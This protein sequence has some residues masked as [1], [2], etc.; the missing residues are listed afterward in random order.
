MRAITT[1]GV[2]LV[3]AISF[4]IVWTSITLEPIDIF[5]LRTE[6]AMVQAQAAVLQAMG[7]FLGIVAMVLIAAYSEISRKT[8]REREAGERE[9]VRRTEAERLEKENRRKLR[10][11]QRH[12][13]S[14]A[15]NLMTTA[16]GLGA[17]Y[18]RLD[19][20]SMTPDQANAFYYE[21]IIWTNGPIENTS[22]F[23]RLDD[24][25]MELFVDLVSQIDDYRTMHARLHGSGSE[26]SKTELV[27][28]HRS[29]HS[30]LQSIEGK[31]SAAANSVVKA[32]END[33]DRW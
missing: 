17:K 29:L 2:L 8:E 31:S 18:Y 25:S 11:Y 5:S 6:D 13:I 22:E 14:S 16:N 32:I 26:H 23:H 19:P 4:V 12:M 24:R 27:S 10:V 28:L 7:S 21:S 33:G 20:E 9:A 1:L 15:H 3:I 30:R